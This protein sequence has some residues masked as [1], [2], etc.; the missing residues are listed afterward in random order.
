MKFQDD[1]PA[2]D[3]QNPIK[4][5]IETIKL[6]S[7]ELKKLNSDQDNS[8]SPQKKKVVNTRKGGKK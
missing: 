6:I 3:T 1:G 2:T 5:D 7:L 8:E 4:L